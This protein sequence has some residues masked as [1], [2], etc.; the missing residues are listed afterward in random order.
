MEF[1]FTEMKREFERITRKMEI[2]K[3]V[4]FQRKMLIAF[5]TAIEFMNTKFD[6]LDLKLDGWSESVHEKSF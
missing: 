4:R 5:V 2:D 6:P 1:D 3:S